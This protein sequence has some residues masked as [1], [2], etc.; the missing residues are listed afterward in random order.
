MK[1]KQTLPKVIADYLRSVP[2]QIMLE[3]M[4]WFRWDLKSRRVEVSGNELKSP[5]EKVSI[6]G[7]L[8]FVRDGTGWRRYA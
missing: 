6:P 1:M 7:T 3:G 4:T 8:V 5:P 2:G